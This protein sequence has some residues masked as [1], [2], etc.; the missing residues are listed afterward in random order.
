[1]W[2]SR[3]DNW[4]RA[5]Y[6]AVEA[7]WPNSPGLLPCWAGTPAFWPATAGGCAAV[8]AER[9]G[10]PGGVTLERWGAAAGREGAERA[11][12]A[13]PRDCRGILRLIWVYMGYVIVKSDQD[14]KRL[15][16]WDTT[17]RVWADEV[18]RMVSMFGL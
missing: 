14:A 18:G 2:G 12:A 1:M 3:K 16:G 10:G 6:A 11:G 15:T 8:V 4:R 13:R 9:A 17:Q 7:I 5:T